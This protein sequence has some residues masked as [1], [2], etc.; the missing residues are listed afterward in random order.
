M[1]IQQDRDSQVGFASRRRKDS[2]GWQVLLLAAALLPLM[3]L[4]GCAGLVSGQ[5]SQPQDTQPAQTY[6]ISGTITPTAGGSGATVTLSGASSGTTTADASGNFSFTGL[7]NGTYVITPSHT[8]YT[9]S[10]ASL[11]VTIA[12]ANVTSGLNFTATAASYNIS[13]TISPTAG[14]SGATVTLSGAGNATTTASASGTYTFTGLGNGT[15]TITPSQTGYTFAPTSQNAT[16]NGANV[17]AVNFT[18]TAQTT[19]TYSISGTISPTAGGNG[20]AVT[21]SGTANASTTANASGNY[22]FSGLANGAY[23]VTPS[24]TGYTFAPVNKAVTLNGANA[25]GVNFTATAAAT[26]SI[27]GTISP[28]AGGSG[29]TVT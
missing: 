4:S 16:I 24:H 27:S 9:F 15:Y 1:R 11:S 23:T 26:Y 8:G 21:L 18:A 17:A 25:A 5:K 2:R 22:T 14:G 3:M 29:A 6:L 7:A 19:P 10:P 12:G 28:T 13:G 20:A